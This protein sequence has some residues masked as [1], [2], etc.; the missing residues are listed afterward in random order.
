MADQSTSSFHDAAETVREAVTLAYDEPS[1][2]HSALDTMVAEFEKA[3][4]LAAA[5]E[6]G[7]RGGGRALIESLAE[8]IRRSNHAMESNHVRAALAEYE[9]GHP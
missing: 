1:E 5:L 9:E 8:A 2:A 3:E 4:I 6:A 7:V